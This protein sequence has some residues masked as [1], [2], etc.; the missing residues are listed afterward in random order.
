MLVTIDQVE[1]QALQ[2]KPEE[3]ADLAERLLETLDTETLELSDFWRLEIEK[4]VA[5]FESGASTIHSASDV[6]KEADDLTS[7]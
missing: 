1:K 7:R 4:R 2:L 6:F 5:A 3:R